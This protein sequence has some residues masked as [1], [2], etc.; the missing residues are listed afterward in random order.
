MGKK[1][2]F[3]KHVYNL[4]AIEKCFVLS[5]KTYYFYKKIDINLNLSL[6][7]ISLLIIGIYI[8]V[9]YYS[10]VLSHLNCSNERWKQSWYNLISYCKNA[11]E[12][13]QTDKTKNIVERTC[14]VTHNYHVLKNKNV[15]N[16]I[17]VYV[18]CLV[19]LC[20][21]RQS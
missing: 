7:D 11:T 9:I 12:W 21:R 18:M 5:T 14:T 2:P 19:R 16:R 13:K 6:S 20:Q 3:T 1:Y 15:S 17:S 8:A 10:D 4:S